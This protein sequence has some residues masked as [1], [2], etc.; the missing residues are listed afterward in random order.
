[1]QACL[2]SRASL[3]APKSVLPRSAR[4]RAPA[5]GRTLRAGP[6]AACG[7]CC[8]LFESAAST[9]ATVLAASVVTYTSWE[10]PTTLNVGAL[11]DV[12]TLRKGALHAA[13]VVNKAVSV[14]GLVLIALAFLPQFASLSAELTFNALVMLGAHAAFSVFRYYGTPI[15][16]ALQTWPQAKGAT[17]VKVAALFLGGMAQ[18]CLAAGYLQ[19]V[20]RA[21]VAYGALNLGLAH[22]VAERADN[23]GA[24]RVPPAGIAAMA[25]AVAAL[26]SVATGATAV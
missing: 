5:A 23:A 19:F 22:F 15:V 21:V 6:R 1:M 25:L 24:M 8:A 17:A 11:A 9:T 7:A 18:Q 4:A 20:S 10:A 26:V 2:S 14:A 3:R 16:P 13:T 12:L